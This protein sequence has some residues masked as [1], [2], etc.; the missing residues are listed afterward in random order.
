[1]KKY[2]KPELEIAKIS[3]EDVITA[4]PYSEEIVGVL[5]VDSYTG[6]IYNTDWSALDWD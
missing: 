5:N 3:V 2:T 6:G 4:S 1:M